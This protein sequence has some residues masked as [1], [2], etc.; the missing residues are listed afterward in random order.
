MS[1]LALSPAK[2]LAA[3]L[4]AKKA[5][6]Q[7]LIAPA[8]FERF[9]GS[10]MSQLKPVNAQGK[11]NA[12][13]RCEPA[14]FYGAC[15]QAALL[16]LQ[17]GILGEVYLVPY[18]RTATLIVG[19]KG[20]LKCARRHPDVVKITATCVYEGDTYERD[21]A[22][23]DV[24]HTTNFSVD[25]SDEKL[26]GA[27]CRVVLANCNEPLS[28]ELNREQIEKRRSRSAAANGNFWKNDYAAMCRKTV[29]RAFF[30]GGELPVSESLER[31]LEHEVEQEKMAE[32]LDVRT[33]HDD[34]IVGEVHNALDPISEASGSPSG[35]EPDSDWKDHRDEQD[36][37]HW[38][39]DSAEAKL[40]APSGQ[41]FVTP[42]ELEQPVKHRAPAKKK[43]ISEIGG[44]GLGD[45][46]ITSTASDLFAETVLD[47]E[48]LSAAQLVRLKEE[49]EK[50]I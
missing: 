15:Y 39:N 17:P 29:I 50:L 24:H 48:V 1:D 16:G 25:K 8:A 44:M 43:T 32:V 26:V 19:Y 7:K 47:I 28:F 3:V 23:G 34:P 45:A 42:E 41:D 2:Q 11:P 27:Y 12:L 20:M 10:L 37:D 35:S 18:G 36:P 38:L 13:L 33:V 46:T 40:D 49:L 5:S 22:T 30:N 4:E 9:M 6:L 14:T 21:G 31:A